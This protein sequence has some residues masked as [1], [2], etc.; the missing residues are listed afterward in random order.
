MKNRLFRRVSR[1]AWIALAMIALLAVAFVFQPVRA[2][3]IDFLGLFR[4]QQVVVV[5]FNPAN[6]P[7]NLNSSQFNQMFSDSLKYD[8][9]GEIHEVPDVAQASQH[10]GFNVR[11]PAALD[12]T[13]KLTVQPG[14]KATIHINLPRTRALLKEIGR[15]DIVL[16]DELDSADVTVELPVSVTAIYGKCVYDARTARKTGRDP[17]EQRS[18]L[19]PDC[20]VFTQLP[21]P[22]ISAPPGLDISQTGKAF[23]MMTGMNSQQANEFSQTIDWSSTLVIP[24]PNY[25]SSQKVSVDGSEGVFVEQT[26]SHGNQTRYLLIWVKNNIVYALEGQGGLTEALAIAGSMK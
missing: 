2:L 9:T 17:D 15:Q 22:T 20:H 1:P 8:Q 25:T 5:P 21:S 10:A 19:S 16:P 14:G 26:Q 3:A 6:L 13:A 11:L 7:D 12:S 18:F 24:I 4:V 23:L